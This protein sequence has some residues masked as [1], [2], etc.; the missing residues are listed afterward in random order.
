MKPNMEFDIEELVLD[1]FPPGDRYLISDALQK[2]LARLFVEGGIPS[3]L[4]LSGDYPVLDAG[5]LQLEPKSN[6]DTIGRRIAG[7]LYQGFQPK[8]NNKERR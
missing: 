2:E 1:G 5:W 4:A 8:T 3:L 6:A 7:T